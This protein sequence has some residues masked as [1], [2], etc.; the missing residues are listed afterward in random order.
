MWLSIF[1]Y[2][3]RNR[4]CAE[5]FVRA[6]GTKTFEDVEAEL[7]NGQKIQVCFV[8]TRSLLCL[9]L[10]SF[11]FCRK[12]LLRCCFSLFPFLSSWWGGWRCCR[13]GWDWATSFEGFM[14]WKN[15]IDEHCLSHCYWYS[16]DCWSRHSSE[17]IFWEFYDVPKKKLTIVV[18]DTAITT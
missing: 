12:L 1:L 8:F 9:F 14:T 13:E 4:R 10:V 5:A 17:S 2:I 7:M 11:W 6:G 16:I 15:Q 18:H 3:G